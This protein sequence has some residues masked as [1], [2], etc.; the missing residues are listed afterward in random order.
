[1]R[2]AGCACPGGPPSPEPT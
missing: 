1:M 2:P